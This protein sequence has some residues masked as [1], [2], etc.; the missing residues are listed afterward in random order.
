MIIINIKLL[1][2]IAFLIISL[3]V[4]LLLGGQTTQAFSI[5][6]FRLK[7]TQAELKYNHFENGGKLEISGNFFKTGDNTAQYLGREG[8]VLIEKPGGLKVNSKLKSLLKEES[9]VHNRTKNFKFWLEKDPEGSTIIKPGKYT[10]KINIS[11]KSN[12]LTENETQKLSGEFNFIVLNED[13]SKPNIDDSESVDVEEKDRDDSTKD[14]SEDTTKEDNKDESSNDNNGSSSGES[15]EDKTETKDKNSTD[16]SN[17]G[18]ES[19]DS[20]SGK[21]ESN[22]SDQENTKS[23][24]EN[25]T[26]HGEDGVGAEDK[27]DSSRDGSSKS[28]GESSDASKSTEDNGGNS[29]LES[30]SEEGGSKQEG[31]KNSEKQTENSEPKENIRVELVNKVNEKPV[32]NLSTDFIIPVEVAQVKMLLSNEKEIETKLKVRKSKNQSYFKK[33]N[34][35]SSDVDTR[36]SYRTE[37]D[38]GDSEDYKITRLDSSQD[39]SNEND[40]QKNEDIYSL[41][42]EKNKKQA[43]EATENGWSIFGINWTWWFGSMSIVFVGFV[44]RKMYKK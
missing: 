42:P 18:N 24:N 28:D 20:S 19:E 36:V 11:D 34:N 44:I 38:G 10:V 2:F 22:E 43:L 4:S 1:K 25:S 14:E 5:N 26:N 21:G 27:D 8:A 7:K 41:K 9:V 3:L 6:E 17:S 35:N 31:G 15:S 16:E 12:A 13:G 32:E 37:S 40:N 29:K 23:D 39:Y 30:E 33:Y